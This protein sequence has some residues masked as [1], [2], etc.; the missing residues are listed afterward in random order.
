MILAIGIL[1]HNEEAQLG[2]LIGDIAHQSILRNPD[3]FIEIHLVANGCTDKTVA[4]AQAAFA[5][6]AFAR[7]NIR[8]FVHELHEP[9]KSNAWNHLIHKY[10]S[11]QSD[12]I[13]LL[14][15]DIRLPEATALSLLFE[16]LASSKSAVVAVDLSVKDLALKSGLTLV[17]RLILK[18]S[19]T[20]HDTRT[21]LAGGCYCAKLSALREI[22]M[23]IGLPGEDGFLRAMLLTSSFTAEEDLERLLFVPSARHIFESER[24]IG[25]VLRHNVRLAIGTAIN[26]LLFEHFRAHPRDARALSAYIR[27]QN[28]TDPKW[29]NKLIADQKRANRYFVMPTSIIW[30]RPKLFAT[31]QFVDQVTK[32]PIFLMGFVFDLAIYLIANRLMRRGAGAGFW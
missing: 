9:G 32:A 3:L 7:P 30:R 26:V 12:Y 17:E 19:G 13:I 8:P 27:E 16:S 18:A 10:A 11:A 31:F 21:A 14:D 22:W 24:R 23:P 5:N 29:V 2:S 1:A 25:D 6:E 15:A 4:V 28:R 20:A